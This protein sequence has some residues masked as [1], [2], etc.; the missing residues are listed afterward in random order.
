MLQSTGGNSSAQALLKE[1][2]K[3]E[4]MF[5]YAH[6]K[7]WKKQ[8]QKKPLPCPPKKRTGA[9]VRLRS[10]NNNDSFPNPIGWGIEELMKQQ[11]HQLTTK[12]VDPQPN[13]SRKQNP[14]DK[15]KRVTNRAHSAGDLP[16]QKGPP[17]F[18]KRLTYAFYD[19]T[20]GIACLYPP[21]RNVARATL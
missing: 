14:I 5:R 21:V 1:V 6:E 19:S 10:T 18:R 15:Q 12:T 16:S 11:Q 17:Y 8:Q 13:H 3:S 20:G 9:S 4:A 2:F 7:S